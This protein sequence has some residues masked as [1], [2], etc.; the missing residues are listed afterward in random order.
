MPKRKATVLVVDADVVHR[1]SVRGILRSNGY[2]VLDAKDFQNAINV[3][4]QYHGEIDLLLTAISLP[5][6]N[7]YDLARSLSGMEPGLMV[8]FVSGETGAKLSQFY[9]AP[10]GDQ[11]HLARPFECEELLDRVRKLLDSES[12]RAGASM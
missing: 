9:G 7:G 11:H 10:W 8:L 2:R 4:Q 12:F 6:G 3:H 5:G 1:Q